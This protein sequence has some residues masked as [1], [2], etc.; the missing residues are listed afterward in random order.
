MHILFLSIFDFFKSKKWLL[1]L[2]LFA[3]VTGLAYAS[4]K[5]ELEEDIT[6]V[7]PSNSEIEEIYAALQSLKNSDRIVVTLSLQDTNLEEKE[8]AL[9]EFAEAFKENLDSLNGKDSLQ[10]TVSI[11]TE[12]NILMDVYDI[13]INNLPIFLSPQDYSSIESITEKEKILEKMENNYK[14]MLSPVGMGLKKNILKDPVG[15]SQYALKHLERLK[16]D[17]NFEMDEGYIFTKDKNKLIC[18]VQSNIPSAETDRNKLLVAN[19]DSALAQA[20]SHSEN[21]VIKSEYFGPA[22]VAV[23]NAIQIKKDIILTISITVVALFILIFYFFRT[24]SSFIMIVIP[25]LF[26]G[27]FS[28]GFLYFFRGE[29][30]IIALGAGSV[31]L[32]IVIDFAIHFY[33]HL[34]H[35]GSIKET[36]TDLSGPLTLG[37]F[38]TIG[39]FLSLLFVN[40]EALQDFGLF[41]AFALVGAAFFILVFYPHFFTKTIQEEMGI[42][43]DNLINKIAG[44]PYDKN[45]YLLVFILCLILV[46]FFTAGKV[47]FDSDM[48]KMNFMTE[49]TRQAEKNLNAISEDSYP[50][51]YVVQ[52]GKSLDEA[53]GK[54]EKNL[55][56]LNELE[57]SSKI[58]KYSN[59]STLMFSRK[60]QQKRIDQ[61]NSYWTSEKK[62]SVMEDVQAAGMDFGFKQGAFQS[63]DGLL[64]KE[65]KPIEIGEY[66]AIQED[67]LDNFVAQVDGGNSLF[68][69]IKV[70]PEMEKE[71]LA[72]LKEKGTGLVFNKKSLTNKFVVLIKDNFNLILGISSILVFFVLLL[73]Y[74][75]IE[76]TLITFIPIVVSWLIILGV[77]GAF[78]LTFNIINIIISTFVFGLGDDYSIFITDALKN[79]YKTGRKN[80]EKFKASIFLSAFTTII[81][82]GV[83]LFAQHP[84]LKSIG[85]IAVIGMGSVLLVSNTLQPALFRWLITDRVKKGNEPLTL[86]GI[87]RSIMAFVVFAI[88]CFSLVPIGAIVLYLLPIPKAKRKKIFHYLR[89]KFSKCIIYFNVHIKK[90]ITNPS[91]EQFETAAMVICNHHSVID[92]L[93]M[94]SLNPKLILMVNDW[95]WNSVFMGPIV[96]MGGFIPKSAGYDENLTLITDLVKEGYSIVIFPEGSRSPSPELRRFHKGAFFI[97]EKLNLDIVPI[98]FHG[99][100]HVQGKE[101]NFL[102][103]PGQVQVKYLPRIKAK[104][105]SYGIG[106]SKR[107]KLISKYFKKEYASLRKEVETTS[108]FY[109]RLRANYIY[110]GP[111]LENYMKVKVRLENNYKLYDSLLPESGTITD[112][113]CGYGFLPLMLGLKN[114][115]RQIVGTDYDQD[116]IE[117][118]QNCFSKTDNIHFKTL[119]ATEE[120]LP[121]SDAYVLSDVLHYLTKKDQKVLLNKMIQGLNE[122]GTILIRDGDKDLTERHKGTKLSEFFST[123]FGFNKT[124]ND[125]EFVSGKYIE[126]I[127]EQNNLRLER[128]DN[129]KRT[130]NIVYIMKN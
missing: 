97:A 24:L 90:T 38:T 59:I 23:G 14:V 54:N 72:I 46:S 64:Q 121:A 85:L 70:K 69:I 27:V 1:W 114:K 98:I 101:D 7:M 50:N 129:T 95:V 82:V 105:E 63:F 16:L 94:Q 127:A 122:N 19:M 51:I 89:S 120:D 80:L 108:Y 58:I 88:G 77:M 84:A 17:N 125:L 117:V 119:D 92:S 49:E 79:E 56:L 25:V 67:V 9:K 74:G 81:G 123:K 26:G 99:T 96:R 115:E 126:E 47:E 116:K 13:Y 5:L 112:I 104:D 113:G 87:L 60:E 6:R 110:K 124:K 40:S 22:V 73:S 42:R 36:I 83:L 43:R 3:I 29:V 109:T 102:L 52:E 62:A 30:S 41:A 91:N 10:S 8:Y 57:S 21:K 76:L 130:S 71:V 106:Y 128:I 118:A 28:L 86:I 18:F 34:K 35:T 12:D 107:T 61:W 37:G 32:G 100:S 78:G 39:A 53:L 45:A 93:L 68:T 55:A 75:R 20:F 4:S 2:V 44:Y 11:K 31:V 103:K 33:A 15:I 48:M 111:V 66:T 65:Y